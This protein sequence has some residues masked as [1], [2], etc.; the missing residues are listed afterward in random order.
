[1]VVKSADEVMEVTVKA[2]VNAGASE[3]NAQEVAEHLVESNL[4]GVDT[5]GVWQ[6]PGYVDQLGQG[7][8]DGRARPAVVAQGPNHVLVTGNWTFGQVAVNFALDRGIEL[9]LAQG[10]AIV[11]V[12]QSYHAGRMGHYV[13]HAA[14]EGVISL[15]FTGGYSEN[16][17]ATFPHG[18]AAPVLHTN[19][20]AFGAPGGAEPRVMFDFATTVLSG[21]KVD[22]ARRLEHQLPPGAIVDRA[23]MATTDP[24]EFFA[25]G[26]HVTFGG[27]KGY[28]LSV[29]S[30]MLSRIFLGTDEYVTEGRG[31]PLFDHQGVT[32]FLVRSDLFTSSSHFGELAD[33]FVH[34]L[35]EIPPKAGS[36]GVLVPGDPEV[37]N[38]QSRHRDGIPIDDDLWA[39][40]EALVPGRVA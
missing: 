27:H 35:H 14:G 4:S 8:I 20:I 2:L 36:N 1:M 29:A 21:V 16:R 15:V 37:R 12:V 33:D 31:G 7:V 40:L 11:G 30:E 22:E 5:H 9:A 32:I 17:P 18:G 10:I 25:G 24:K 13:E 38:R 26:G 23:G 6:L 19:P 28:A 3:D 34:R 39:R